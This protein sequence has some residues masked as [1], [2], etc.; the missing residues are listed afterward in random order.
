MADPAD[1]PPGAWPQLYNLTADPGEA[2]NI[3]PSQPAAV[4]ALEGRL[5]AY[6]S[7]SVEPMQWT[8]PYQGAGYACAA[9]P[10]HPLGG[11]PAEPW[12]AWL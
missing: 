2:T 11:E 10:R 5:A 7:A 6:A 12:T 3:A 8:P 9:C 1:P 4:A